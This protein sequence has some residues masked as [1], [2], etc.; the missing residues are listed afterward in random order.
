MANSL[1]AEGSC[2]PHIGPG[3]RLSPDAALKVKG[4]AYTTPLAP[5]VGAG[6]ESRTFLDMQAKCS[7]LEMFYNS[8][9][10]NNRVMG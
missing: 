7:S 2:I 6:A 5:R 8:F 4:V 9:I 3:A 1:A 10:C